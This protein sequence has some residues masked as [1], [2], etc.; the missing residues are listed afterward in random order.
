M[1][2]INFS[3]TLLENGMDKN[4][5]A[6]ILSLPIIATILSF[7]KYFV[8]MKRIKFFTPI[9][10]VATLFDLSVINGNLDPI[11]GIKYGLPVL[12]VATLA[13]FATYAFLSK[14]VMHFISKMSIIFS[15]SL[16]FVP[17]FYYFAS[18]QES[19]GFLASNNISILIAVLTINL[20]SVSLL[21]RGAI[22]A[23]KTIIENILVALILF[24][25]I[26]L[27]AVFDFILKYPE[28][29]LLAILL[30]IL[31]GKYTGLRV[32]ELIRFSGILN[33]K[34]NQEDEIIKK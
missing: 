12:T 16:L 25:L 11:S 33:V 34:K 28:T 24:Y 27:P 31:I 18:Q 2:D 21:R 22:S 6:L 32:S 9:L 7:L 29:V 4:T 19:Y 20:F 8:G 5:L 15:L 30:N 23:I 1:L 26:T 14:T 13:V 3:Q 10:V 17:A